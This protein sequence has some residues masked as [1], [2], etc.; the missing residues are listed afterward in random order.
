MK[1]VTALT[2]HMGMVPVMIFFTMKVRSHRQSWRAEA[3]CDIA[4]NIII[5]KPQC[6]IN[7]KL[8]HHR[9]NRKS[10]ARVFNAVL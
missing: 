9:S 2:L 4:Q 10:V 1:Q 7:H 6:I 8:T 5:I 3:S